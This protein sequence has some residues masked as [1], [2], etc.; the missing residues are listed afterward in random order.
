VLSFVWMRTRFAPFFRLNK[1]VFEKN[2]PLLKFFQK[3]EEVKADAYRN[4]FLQYL[5]AFMLENQIYGYSIYMYLC[6]S[7]MHGENIILHK[8]PQKEIKVVIFLPK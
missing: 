5:S 1:C 8:R 7:I 2:P 6:L 4:N 3:A